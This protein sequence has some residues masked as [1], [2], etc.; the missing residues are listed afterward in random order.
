MLLPLSALNRVLFLSV[1]GWPGEASAGR[2]GSKTLL[3]SHDSAGF[4]Q[5]C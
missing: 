2:G 4:T 3:G 5:W 1:S